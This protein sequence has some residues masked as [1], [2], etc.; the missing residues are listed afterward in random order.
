MNVR[1]WLTLAVFFVPHVLYAAPLVLPETTDTLLIF[2]SREL[3]RKL[4]RQPW[5]IPQTVLFAGDS[6]MEGVGPV[7]ATM[8]ANRTGLT[9]VQAGRS[10]TGL[11]RPDFYD[12][13]KAM[14][15]YMR[16]NHPSVVVFC[17]G[18]NDD[19]SVTDAGARYHFDSPRW[20]QAYARKVE[21]II[22]IIAENG[23]VSIWVSAPIMGSK[24]MRPRVHAIMEVIRQTCENKN[25][26][27]VDVWGTL[28]DGSGNYQY[29]A[30]TPNGKRILL[31]AKDGVHVTS[32]GNKMLAKTVYSYVDKAL[33]PNGHMEAP[34][35]IVKSGAANP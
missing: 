24:A 9:F 10:S 7:M 31:R 32:A 15:T 22:N 13:P 11:C 26:T 28:A 25:V 1:I 17:I 14:R 20:K 21:E 4:V 23:A 2:H 18:T 34:A 27:F 16:T 5:I 8:L 33:T 35:S 29:A 30:L 3:S 12:W 19:Q 6:I